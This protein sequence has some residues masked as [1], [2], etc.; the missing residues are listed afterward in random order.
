MQGFKEAVLRDIC[1]HRLFL[2]MKLQNKQASVSA[3]LGFFFSCWGPMDIELLNKMHSVLENLFLASALAVLLASARMLCPH[4]G[5]LS[6]LILS[7]WR[8]VS[9]F[10]C[11]VTCYCKVGKMKCHIWVYVN[12]HF[13]FTHRSLFCI[14][15]LTHYPV[16]GHPLPG[17]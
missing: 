15:F 9:P 10:I 2:L 17:L 7:L 6:P 5:S 4:L 11:V 12:I 13:W 16:S 14:Y 8:I 3:C 1:L